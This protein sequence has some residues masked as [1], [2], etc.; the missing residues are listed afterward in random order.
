MESIEIPQKDYL[1]KTGQQLSFYGLSHLGINQCLKD[2]SIFYVDQMTGTSSLYIKKHYGHP[3]ND[4]K[5]SVA[6]RH[7]KQSK[8]VSANNVDWH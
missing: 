6:L 5:R 4:S 8:V 7:T 2:N 3:S 1:D